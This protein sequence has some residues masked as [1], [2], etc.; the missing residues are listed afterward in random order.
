LT[1]YVQHFGCADEIRNFSNALAAWS[2]GIVSACHATEEIGAMGF[3]I[4]S[5]Q[6]IG[7]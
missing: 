4:K 3:E 6:V 1:N 2:F 7:L 5:L